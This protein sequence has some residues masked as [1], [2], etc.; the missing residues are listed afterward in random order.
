[1]DERL[2][3]VDETVDVLWFHSSR[4]MLFGKALA[5]QLFY[6]F[7]LCVCF[8]VGIQDPFHT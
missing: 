1:M 7:F 2:R 8:F 4:L 3:I 5:L 6:T